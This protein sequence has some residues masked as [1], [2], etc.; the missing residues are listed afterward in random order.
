MYKIIMMNRNEYVISDQDYKNLKGMSGLTH[1]KSIDT[2]INLNSISEIMI[3]GG[4]N[5]TKRLLSDGTKA[6]KKF[7]VWYNELSDAKIDINYYP[8]LKYKDI[9]DEDK[10]IGETSEF[11][12][13]LAA[14]F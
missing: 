6:V 12:K 10:E 4:T 1:I 9:V 14:K 2:I 11:A 3:L 5:D 13:K 7:G 8:E